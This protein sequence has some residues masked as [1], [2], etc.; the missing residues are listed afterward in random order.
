MATL[1]A[2][3][4]TDLRETQA[5]A[6]FDAPTAAPDLRAEAQNASEAVVSVRGVPIRIADRAAHAIRFGYF[7]LGS[8]GYHSL[9]SDGSDPRG[10][11][12]LAK[13]NDRDRSSSMSRLRAACAEKAGTPDARFSSFIGFG[14]S[15]AKVAGHVFLAPP[16]DQDRLL[17]AMA[18]A[19]GTAA[20]YAEPGYAEPANPN[21]RWTLDMI[22]AEAGRLE[23]LCLAAEELLASIA[24]QRQ[25]PVL[26]ARFVDAL[27]DSPVVV[28]PQVVRSWIAD[29]VFD[30]DD[31]VEIPEVAAQVAAP[32]YEADKRGQYRLF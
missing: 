26:W 15:L 29:E 32:P 14:L 8:S 2:A 19:R 20:R 18:D 27:P 31:D 12:K 1:E 17:K 21:S 6:G 7:P 16:E 11:E 9:L 22:T 4:A 13:E 10:L 5:M 25:S 28:V 3:A 23:A 30:D 24:G